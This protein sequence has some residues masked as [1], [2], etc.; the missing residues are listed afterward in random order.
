MTTTY[1]V[2][3]KTGEKTGTDTE[4]NV[5][6]VLEGTEG[7]KSETIRLNSF[8]SNPEDEYDDDEEQNEPK[9]E[10]E[11]EEEEEEEEFEEE[12]LSDDWPEA[13][14][15]KVAVLSLEDLGVIQRITLSSDDEHPDADWYIEQVRVIRNGMTESA[16]TLNAWLRKD[17]LPPAAPL[18][19]GT[20]PPHAMPQLTVMPSIINGFCEHKP[21][22]VIAHGC[23][24]REQIRESI[25]SG[26]NA[27]ECD[28]Q[29]KGGGFYVDHDDADKG[30]E[31]AV[32][33]NSVVEVVEDYPHL[34]ALVYFDIKSD[35]GFYVGEFIDAVQGHPAF[36]NTR[37]N[38]VY[39]VSTID[40]A[41]KLRFG[42]N[43]YKLVDSAREVFNI[44]F[45]AIDANKNNVRN[46]YRDNNIT[47][48]WYGHGIDVRLPI[49]LAR[50]RP[51]LERANLHRG[52]GDGRVQKTVSWSYRAES[53]INF[54]FY[55]YGVYKADALIVSIGAIKTA[56]KCVYA[57]LPGLRLAIPE[58]SPCVHNE[59]WYSPNVVTVSR[60]DLNAANL[61]LNRGTTQT[62]IATV[63]PPNATN[64]SFRWIST[65]PA[66][67]TVDANGVVTAIAQG[68]T[69]IRAQA[70][71]MA[72]IPAGCVVSASCY[73]RVVVLITHITLS[74]TALTLARGNTRTLTATI[75]PDDATNKTLSWTSNNPAVAT[76][77]D[78]GL[79]TAMGP[80][81]A[82]I[83]AETTDGS[84][85]SAYCTVT[86]VPVLSNRNLTNVTYES[87]ELTV[88]SNENATA[89]W[90][91]LPATAPTPTAAQIVAG[92]GANTGAMTAN[93]PFSRRLSGLA[94]RT[95]YRLH[96]VALSNG[97][98]SAV[99]S[100]AFTTLPLPIVD[101]PTGLNGRILTPAQTGDTANWVEIARNGNYA[102]IIRSEFINIHP[103]KVMSGKTIW[104]DPQWQHT[105]FGSTL[106]YMTAAN[107]IRQK[108]NAWFN[109]TAQ[110][111]AEKLPANA[112]LRNFT[113]QTNVSQALG[114]SSWPASV[115]DGFTKP[116]RTLLGTGD[117]IAFAL[118]YGEAAN[119]VSLFYFLRGV[120]IA[121]QPSSAIAQANFA[122][123]SIP[124]SY[125]Y[126]GM[127]LR[128][129]GDLPNTA[130]FLSSSFSQAVPGRV[131]QAYL[132]DTTTRGL[133]YPAL[134]V[135]EYIFSP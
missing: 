15:L 19:G 51:S 42:A 113:V 73:V 7:R 124:I 27:V 46:F 92:A 105:S 84:G 29:Y 24:K 135:D 16:F 43:H 58:D 131:F 94:S 37:L 10:D 5:D 123:I 75:S 8:F 36:T 114:T 87:A 110:G 133:L 17:S 9:D 66:V 120:T 44:D 60:I 104:G 40:K 20:P 129:P 4:P 61:V 23:N 31:L 76:V 99:W 86:V 52:I 79:V 121:N 112:R 101:V 111:E 45:E 50:V 126:Y 85:V 1:T 25:K 70:T 118:S 34:F 53:S 122:K 59:V 47:R 56:L 67:A 98:F 33:L 30:D 22:Y 83:S 6:I 62:L 57:I 26:A 72:G 134:W 63:S 74:E 107:S 18:P 91:V 115:N 128:S 96:F 132:S 69:V 108:L 21:V 13:D 32:W 100:E 82:T 48:C 68:T 55:R 2:L 103:N 28:I 93:A 106:N 125:A 77:N 81:V 71:D 130:A 39:S 11:G 12:N 89:H 3:I 95:A 117:D 119:F 80:G 41:K 49:W 64:P 78:N 127:W 14:N 116:T 35:S 65:T 102:L 88:T 97:A 109:G 90:V 38:F 54:F